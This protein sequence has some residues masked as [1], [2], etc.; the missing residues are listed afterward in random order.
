MTR[1]GAAVRPSERVAPPAWSW[2]LAPA[3]AVSLAAFLL[4]AAQAPAAGYAVLAAGVV[5]AFALDRALGKDLGLIALGIAI[6][7]T[8]SVEADLEWGR[9]FT[10]GVVLT[11]AV[12]VP[13]AVDRFVLRR[14]AIIFPW[15]SGRSWPPMEKAYLLL[16]PFLGWALL[17]FYFI[18]SGA[19]LNWPD[20]TTGSELARFFVGVNAVGTWDELFFICTCFALLRRHFPVWQANVLQ[21]TIFVSFLWELGYREWGPAFTIPFALLQGYIFTRTR[22]LTYVL[23]VHLL[24]DAIVFLAIVHAH[25]PEM[26]RIFVY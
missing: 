4:F 5:G 9:F 16:V 26:F 15:R 8:T 3:A 22:S 1:P 25:N 18:R 17:P 10:L 20:I 14:R 19:Y 11:L 7:S 12:L 23:V 6:V 13:F 21:A 24:F 2:A